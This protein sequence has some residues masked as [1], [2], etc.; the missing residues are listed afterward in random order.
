MPGAGQTVRRLG[1]ARHE[2]FFQ[3]EIEGSG[4]R[5][6]QNSSDTSEQVFPLAARG[7]IGSVECA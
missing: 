3:N 1:L 6:Y 4:T 7:P 2:T 5:G